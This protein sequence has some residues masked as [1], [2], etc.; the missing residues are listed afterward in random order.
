MR[1]ILGFSNITDLSP[2]LNSGGKLLF[3]TGGAEPATRASTHCYSRTQA[4]MGPARVDSF[5]RYYEILMTPEFPVGPG[6]LDVARR[7]GPETGN[8]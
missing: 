2:F 3:G 1:L 5:V 4:A 6:H 7:G 8:R